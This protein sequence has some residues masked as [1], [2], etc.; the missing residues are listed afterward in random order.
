[1]QI[2]D[3]LNEFYL[4]SK[5]SI[6]T[7]DI[8]G[9]LIFSFKHPLI[10][11]FPNNLLAKIDFQIQA[12]KVNLFNTNQNECFSTLYLPQK[13][14]HLIILWCSTQTIESLG[15]FRDNFPSVSLERLTHYTKL[16]YFIFFKKLPDINAP[17]LINDKNLTNT[18]N[19]GK[20]NDI[21]S[22]KQYHNN[23]QK[24][25]LMLQS[26]SEGNLPAFQFWLTSFIKSGSF[27][28]MALGNKLRNGKNL[29]IAATTVFT[30]AA[31]RGGMHPEAAFVL[32]DKCIQ[33]IEKLGKIDNIL[34]LI[35]EIGELFVKRVRM[36]QNFS[37]STII[38]LIQDYIFKHLN[39]TL[40]LENIADSLSYSKQYLCRVFKQDTGET[41]IYYANEQKIR[42][43]CNQLIFSNNNVT[44]IATKLGFCDQSYLTKLFVKHTSMTPIA[45]RKKYHM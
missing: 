27:G 44:E 38:F 40:R 17:K 3:L 19:K 28:Q 36:A 33:R 23:Y 29:L 21:I 34:E 39:E 18:N 10:P 30:R 4:A 22:E 35:Q 14:H 6:F 9:K 20:L 37:N 12:G 8:N 15:N 1:M 16:L 26:L 13:Q 24:E 42:E 41:I 31:I 2:T 11:D 32:S 43:V 7:Y 45:F 5:I 25:K